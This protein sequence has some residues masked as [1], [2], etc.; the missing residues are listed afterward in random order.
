MDNMRK[1]G[2]KVLVDFMNIAI[3]F[4]DEMQKYP[5]RS[6]EIFGEQVTGLAL[7]GSNAPY[8]ENAPLIFEKEE[9]EAQK[10]F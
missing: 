5:Y 1:K 10:Y 7:L 9:V 8:F 6:V 3:S 2:K 4:K